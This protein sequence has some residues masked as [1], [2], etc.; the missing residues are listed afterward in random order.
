MVKGRRWSAPM[1]GFRAL[2]MDMLSPDVA[3]YDVQSVVRR[4][5]SGDEAAFGELMAEHEPSILRTAWRML[6]NREDARDVAQEVFL[7]LHRHIRRIDADKDPGGWLHRTD[8]ER[9]GA[10]ADARRTLASVLD[11]LSARER[12]VVVLRDLEGFEV[13]EVARA[14][15][16][17]QVTVRAHLS[18]SRLKLRTAMHE[19]GGRR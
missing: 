16:C 7:R 8:Q 3:E 15:G 2:T 4:A 13:K 18:R 1:S 14:L 5:R 9:L 11:V 6:G 17:R 12:A 10:A 19:R